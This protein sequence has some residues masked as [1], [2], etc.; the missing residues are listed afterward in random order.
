MGVL[1]DL[2]R[3]WL[4]RRHSPA[5]WRLRPRTI[6]RRIFRHVVI[7][8]EYALPERFHEGDTVLDIGGHVGS[9]S[10]AALRRGA[11]SV[12]VCEPDADN[13]A[14][15]VHNLAP[16]RDRVRLRRQAVWRESVAALGMHNPID[17]RNTGAGQ[18]CL[19]ATDRAV[20][21]VAFDDLVREIAGEGRVRLV[22][23]DC[24]GAEWPIL[25]TS[26]C[27]GLIDELCGE[28]HLAP[29]PE[30]FTVPGYET[31]AP[32]DLRE[33][34]ERTGFSVRLVPLTGVTLPFMSYGGSSVV[35]NFGLIALLLVMSHRSRL[36]TATVTA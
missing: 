1:R 26:E 13:F 14:L 17:S 32:K 36:P 23:L 35:T 11:G 31:F 25:L 4:V 7:D 24:E 10:L 22:K 18:V 21:A 2:Y 27:L 33:C 15:L 5:H 20:E 12:H 34:L 8:N 29:L 19:E 3:N 16:Y 30:A 6:D 9:F 28:Y